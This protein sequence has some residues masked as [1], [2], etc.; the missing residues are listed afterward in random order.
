MYN[1]VNKTNVVLQGGYLLKT[2]S[3][4]EVFE[5]LKLYKITTNE[6]SVRRWLRTGKLVGYRNSKKE[7][8]RVRE[9]D[10]LQFI[11]ARMPGFNKTIDLR[12]IN[13]T[14]IALNDATQEEAIRE[15]MWFEIVQKNIFEGFVDIK[16]TRLKEC[17]EHRS[18]SKDFFDYC[19]EQLN[20]KKSNRTVPRLPYLLDS[21]LY[22]SQKIK[23]DDNFEILEEK[24][25]FALIE[26]IRLKK[27][28]R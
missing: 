16:K 17:I 23:F 5:Q 25:I 7:G 20:Q 4:D 15:K 14:G 28:K 13:T 2:Y 26:Y 3:V 12:T 21:F 9:E 11:N 19:W 6:E 18:L 10:L 24:V 22:D 27:I 8:W 1:L